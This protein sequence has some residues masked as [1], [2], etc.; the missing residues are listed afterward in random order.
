MED[1]ELA[2]RLEIPADRDSIRAVETAAFGRPDEAAIVDAIRGAEDEVCSIVGEVDG[3]VL[4][5]AFFTRVA[6]AGMPSLRAC[7]LGPVA[8]FPERQSD[9]VGGTVIREGIA[10]CKADGWQ[11]MFVLG[12][13][14]YY[15][16]FG[17][18]LAAS[19]GFHYASHDFD[20]AFQMKW[21]SG[22]PANVAGGWVTYHRAFG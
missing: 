3:E 16:R 15:S 22:P 13:P 14:R 4:G 6:A 21:L 19:H 17:F 8:V 7:A 18:E 20:R 1:H 9:G 10:R 2:V 11:A 12:D 5:H